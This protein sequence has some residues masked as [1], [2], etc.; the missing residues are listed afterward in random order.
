MKKPTLVLILFL[1]LKVFCLADAQSIVVL[2]FADLSRNQGMH[3]M[4]ES[5]PELLEDRLKRPTINVLGREERMIAFDRMGIPY[6]SSLS[7]ASL[8]KIGQEL[9]ASILLLGDFNSNGDRIETSVSILD[10]KRNRLTSPIREEGELEQYQ[11]LCGRMAWKVLT[12]IDPSFPLNLD[13]FLARFPIIPNV[14]HENYI[15]G[16]IESDGIKQIRFFRQADRAYPNY[17]KAI[18]QLGKIYHQQKDYATSSLWLQRLIK[19]DTEVL[20]AGFLLGL[21]ELYLKHYEKAADEFQRLSSVIPLKEVFN[22]LGISWSLSGSA[23]SATR[24]FQN[25]LEGDPLEADY[26]FNLANH[27][28]KTGNFSGAVKKLKEVIQRSESDAEAHYLLYKCYHAI[29]K[30]SEAAAALALAM[31]LSPKIESWENRKQ[32]PELFRIQS[33]FDESSFHQLQLEIRQIQES[34]LNPKSPAERTAET[35]GK[36]THHLQSRELDQ[37]EKLLAQAIQQAPESADARVLMGKVLEA[38]G[39]KARAVAEYRASLWLQESASTRVLLSRLYL[40]LDRKK[41]AKTQAT[42]AL[43]REP[44]NI[45][46]KEILAKI[47]SQ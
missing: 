46:A 25:A 23:E 22:N 33:S 11:H 10:L 27:F 17:S 44:G 20:E 35:I 28:W 39:E 12:Q 41:E 8:I 19:L 34:K 21:N 40:S 1:F 38:K 9:D 42:M 18:F 16:L 24:A 30:P 13:S 29:G 3:W 14:A 36:A 7:K 32:I 4:S 47:T 15:R 45:E 43:D 2:P 31:Q 26:Y 37:A 6:T 5:F